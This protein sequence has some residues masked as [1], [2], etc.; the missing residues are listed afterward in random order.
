MGSIGLF[1]RTF[2][3]VFQTARLCTEKEGMMRRHSFVVAFLVCAFFLGLV[4]AASADETTSLKAI[5]ITTSQVATQASHNVTVEQCFVANYNMTG[6]IF[7]QPA[8]VFSLD[9]DRVDIQFSIYVA[10]NAVA[11]GSVYFVAII[12]DLATHN[13]MTLPLG[14]NGDALDPGYH[15]IYD[16]DL[17]DAGLDVG[18]GQYAVNVYLYPLGSVDVMNLNPN[19]F[20]ISM[21]TAPMD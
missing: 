11:K 19:T 9:A 10:T 18:A 15:Y 14:S 12:Y 6:S 20:H 13:V 4:C 1:N 21:F 16:I 17:W 8:T 3:K 5:A 2:L 7:A